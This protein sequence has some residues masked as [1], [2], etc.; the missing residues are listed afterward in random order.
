M[1]IAEN[2][3]RAWLV[4]PEPS[5]ERQKMIMDFLSD[6]HKVDIVLDAVLN[7]PDKFNFESKAPAKKRCKTI[8]FNIT[9]V[10]DGDLNDPSRKVMDI[11]QRL[12]LKQRMDFVT[13]AV[14]DYLVNEAERA[15]QERFRSSDVIIGNE[16]FDLLFCTD[17]GEKYLIPRNSDIMCTEDGIDA[18]IKKWIQKHE[19]I[20]EHIKR[21]SARLI[22]AKELEEH[23][24]PPLSSG[25]AYW[26][27]N[28]AGS[29]AVL[30]DSLGLLR[31]RVPEGAL[32]SVRPVF[33]YTDQ[34][35]IVPDSMYETAAMNVSDHLDLAKKTEDEMVA[36]DIP[37]IVGKDRMLKEIIAAREM[38]SI[39]NK[40]FLMLCKKHGIKSDIK[41]S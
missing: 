37:V 18:G 28:N 41:I 20:K 31:K 8:T 29:K 21:G 9:P 10:I 26:V 33:L 13:T 16:E 24:I 7:Y 3:S 34:R 2:K 17:S 15:E 1:R 30:M 35:S 27:Q 38:C 6:Y 4:L 23:D 39:S 32:G 14:Y 22:L 36:G 11:V 5:N 12:P 19:K 25:G 40:D